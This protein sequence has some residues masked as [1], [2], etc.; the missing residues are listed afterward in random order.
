MDVAR[1]AKSKGAKKVYVIYRRAEEQMPAERKE[2]REAKEE[3]IEFLFQNNIVR[4]L[5]TKNEGKVDQIEC[6]KTQLVKKEN[7]DRLSP[8]NIEGSNYIL[9]I[10]YVIM[11]I[12]S[13]PEKN[14]TDGLN[15]E[16][17]N[18]GYIKVNEKFQTSD[19][20]V[21]AGGDII[22]TEATIA[23]AARDGREAAKSIERYLKAESF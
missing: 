23:W 2:I 6:I 16:L 7:D 13:K 9:D 12:G 20:R 15:L 21:F 11:A 1:T 22:G 5:D 4:I 3:G 8:V 14:V 17:T 10:D 18:K 19:D